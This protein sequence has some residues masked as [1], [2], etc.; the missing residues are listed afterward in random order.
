MYMA[1]GGNPISYQWVPRTKWKKMK[2]RDDQKP[3]NMRITHAHTTHSQYIPIFSQ[4]REVFFNPVAND[5]QNAQQ[6]DH[7]NSSA[8]IIGK[9]CTHFSQKSPFNLGK[10]LIMFIWQHFYFRYFCSNKIYNLPHNNMTAYHFSV[11]VRERVL[12]FSSNS[13]IVKVYLVEHIN[14]QCST[15][16][17][18]E[19]TRAHI[20]T[21]TW[22]HYFD[23]MPCETIE[24]KRTEFGWSMRIKCFKRTPSTSHDNGA[25]L[26]RIAIHFEQSDS[27]KVPIY[28]GNVSLL[29]WKKERRNEEIGM[30]FIIFECN[31]PLQH[32]WI[33]ASVFLCLHEIISIIISFVRPVRYSPP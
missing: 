27:S 8:N 32:R 14:V 33:S 18:E 16:Y 13:W 5:Q 3:R 30:I 28:I 10:L 21:L 2:Q 11:C 15:Q 17:L 9:R 22:N 19:H 20:Q 4:C 12:S 31:S 26:T 29:I 23:G 25:N 6:R 1:N 7:N 24:R